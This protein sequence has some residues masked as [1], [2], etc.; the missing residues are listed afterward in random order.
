MLTGGSSLIPAVQEWLAEEYDETETYVLDGEEGIARGATILAN[1]LVN[2]GGVPSS[3]RGRDTNGQER[4]KVPNVAIDY[5]G[6]AL[7]LLEKP[8][9]DSRHE[10]MAAE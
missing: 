3:G 7:A 1:L 6:G 5:N 4:I 2:E 10:H 8:A 9:E